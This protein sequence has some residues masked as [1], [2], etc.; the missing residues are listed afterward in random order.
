MIASRKN[1]IQEDASLKFL[2]ALAPAQVAL[3][4]VGIPFCNYR[5]SF[6]WFGEK[7]KETLLKKN[8]FKQA[9]LRALK[10]EIMVKLQLFKRH[11]DVRPVCIN[12][13]GGTPT[14]LSPEE[15][16]DIIKVLLAES[17]ARH[18]DL[19]EINIEATP[20]TMTPEYVKKL[21]TLCRVNRVSLGLQFV[22]NV[23]LSQAKR[24]HSLDDF[25]NAYAALRAAGIENINIDLMFGLPGQTLPMVKKDLD[26]V[27]GL[28]PEHISPSPYTPTKESVRQRYV[29]ARYAEKIHDVLRQHGYVNYVHK[30]HCRDQRIGLSQLVYLSGQPYLGFGLG[31]TSYCNGVFLCNSND[32]SEYIGNP[33]SNLPESIRFE[34]HK[35]AIDWTYLLTSVMRFPQGVNIQWFKSRYGVDIEKDLKNNVFI[36]FLKKHNLLEKT[37]DNFLRIKHNKRFSKH[38]W[39]IYCKPV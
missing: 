17:G 29:G 33:C 37:A 32:M 9:Y 20:D 10:T 28:D 38:V 2:N 19:L 4:Y 39:E 16:A 34:M 5:C 15:I 12:F 21:K 24:E 25:Q 23:Q 8:D 31:A 1:R 13:G 27:L 30:Y 18:R 36:A 3:F 14:I 35:D 6:C 7:F 26:F 11:A 22:S